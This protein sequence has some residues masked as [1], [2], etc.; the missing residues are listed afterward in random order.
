M[1]KQKSILKILFFISLTFLY[2]QDKDFEKSMS[3][4]EKKIKELK[5]AIS[6][7][8]S[9]ITLLKT[10]AQQTNNILAITKKNIQNSQ[11]LIKA[12]D[13]KITLYNKQ[14]TNL[15]NAIIANN[16]EMELIKKLELI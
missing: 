9:E 11:N 16:N 14:S 12:Y 2:A 10:R 13:K 7:N 5:E 3:D 15:R 8:N 1:N 4:T 6:Q